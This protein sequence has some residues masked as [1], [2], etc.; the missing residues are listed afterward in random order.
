MIISQETHKDRPNFTYDLASVDRNT[1]AI[2]I[3]DKTINLSCL[4]EFQFEKVWLICLNQKTFENVISQISPVYVSI[5]GCKVKDLSSLETLTKVETIIKDWNTKAVDFWDFRKNLKLQTL[6]IA[7]MT[8][9]TSL[10]KLSWATSLKKLKITGGFNFT[11]K[12]TSLK[13]LETL[14]KLTWL[15]L[16]N[17]NVVDKSLQPLS[18]LINLKTLE[19]TNQ[20]PTAEFAKLST[21][22]KNTMCDKFHP[23]TEV[24]F[25]GVDGKL[26]YDVMIT[27]SRKP[28]L[29]SQRDAEKI[30]TYVQK[31]NTMVAT[32]EK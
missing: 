31:F 23:Y 2:A 24:E 21:Q 26:Q 9:V 11:W 32:F 30:A 27:G 20:F 4:P 22:L 1:K 14:T 12:F 8:K 5:Y 25:L 3:N 13:P 28:F 18:N 16:A 15:T 17:V 6:Y 7:N 19:L 10:E 29:N